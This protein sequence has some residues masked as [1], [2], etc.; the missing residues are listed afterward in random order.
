MNAIIIAFQLPLNI[1]LNMYI[2]KACGCVGIQWLQVNN[3]HS[4][5][6]F[7]Q[8]FEVLLR[9]LSMTNVSGCTVRYLNTALL[10]FSSAAEIPFIA[11]CGTQN[12]L[13]NIGAAKHVRAGNV[14]DEKCISATVWVS[15]CCRTDYKTAISA[16][17]LFS[18]QEDQSMLIC[19]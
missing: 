16:H 13:F 18:P 14:T 4:E 3:R 12:V 7:G 17:I 2:C 9:A 5:L 11:V 6:W 15:L 19:T 1:S 8:A 10:A